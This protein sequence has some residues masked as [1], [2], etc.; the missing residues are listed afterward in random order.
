MLKG[1][2]IGVGEVSILRTSLATHKQPAAR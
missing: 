1:E 2:A